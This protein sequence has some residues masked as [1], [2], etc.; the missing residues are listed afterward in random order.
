MVSIKDRIEIV[1]DV[2]I[3]KDVTANAEIQALYEYVKEQNIEKYVAIDRN[4]NRYMANNVGGNIRL[5]GPE[6]VGLNPYYKPSAEPVEPAIESVPEEKFSEEEE[7]QGAEPITDQ[8]A[9]EPEIPLNEEVEIAAGGP[10]EKDEM[11]KQLGERDKVI[12]ELKTEITHLQNEIKRLKEKP[13][14]LEQLVVFIKAHGYELII[15]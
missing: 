12:E 5:P 9:E 8:P 6:D 4:G 15:K 1:D 14:T 3:L 7:E 13:F 11:L 2:A 10:A